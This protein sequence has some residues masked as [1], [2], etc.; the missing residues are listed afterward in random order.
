M[1]CINIPY[2][3]DTP[4]TKMF[5]RGMETFM[6]SRVVSAGARNVRAPHFACRVS[7]EARNV[8]ALH[9]ACRV[10]AEARNV[11]A[12][13][14]AYRASPPANRC[15]CLRTARSQP[16][17]VMHVMLMKMPY[18]NLCQTHHVVYTYSPHGDTPLH[19]KG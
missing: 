9:S 3:H 7:A 14:S 18:Q 6:L 2:I 13:R 15:R 1:G 12:P 16:S 8:R 17:L 5:Y 19:A 4:N 10:L 11:H